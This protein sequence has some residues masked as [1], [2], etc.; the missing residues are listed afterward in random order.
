MTVKKVSMNPIHYE[1]A[2]DGVSIRAQRDNKPWY[3]ARVLPNHLN[4]S[5]IAPAIEFFNR[6][7][8]RG[9]TILVTGDRPRFALMRTYPEDK[10]DPDLVKLGD[11]RIHLRCRGVDAWLD[12]CDAL[13][14]VFHPGSTDYR[15]EFETLPQL[16]IDLLVSQA[17]DWGLAVELEVENQGKEAR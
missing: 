10:L 12:E 11:G 15:L 17:E 1:M 4:F 6:G 5:K 16:K 13:E 14:V 7:V 9:D 2:A 3:V 8:K